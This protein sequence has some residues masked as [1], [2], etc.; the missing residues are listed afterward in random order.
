M[1]ESVVT[2]L[3]QPGAQPFRLDVTVVLSRSSQLPK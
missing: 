2:L 1:S 3:L